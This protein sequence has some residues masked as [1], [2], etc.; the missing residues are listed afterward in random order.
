M[1]NN[2]VDIIGQQISNHSLNHS[3]SKQMYT[4]PKSKRFSTGLKSCSSTTF[5]YNLPKVASMR[6]TSLGFGTKSDFTKAKNYNPPFYHIHRLFDYNDG[7]PHYS[8]GVSRH[9]NRS[10]DISP[11]PGKYNT[12]KPFGSDAPKYSIEKKYP[13]ISY[14]ILENVPGPGTYNN[15]SKIF[16]K[17]VLSNIKNSSSVGFTHEKRFR[18][19][20]DVTPGPNAYKLE[21]L[22]NGKGTIFDSRFKSNLGR[23]IFFKKKDYF[24]VNDT[25][26][27]GAYNMFSEFGIYGINKRLIKLT[28]KS[29]LH[30]RK[31]NSQINLREKKISE[32]Y[33]EKEEI[34]MDKEKNN[35]NNSNKKE[36]K[37]K[38]KK[39][40]QDKTKKNDVVND[41]K[42]VNNINNEN[43]DNN[44]NNENND[45]NKNNENNEN[46][47]NKINLD[48]KEK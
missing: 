13:V 3:I 34:E 14:S 27:P 15:G 23:T 24:N 31:S 46:S 47:E 4:F 32:S 36:K 7:S 25:P 30:K 37:K 35:I 1:L 20:L 17:Y 12:S 22:I 11:G 10:S 2:S 41:N 18:Q 9:L 40:T 42:D 26:G 38:K 43:N 8:F 44:E 21:N 39:K 6:A 48:D 33:L 5:Y 19:H 16:G 28:K 29:S 45:N